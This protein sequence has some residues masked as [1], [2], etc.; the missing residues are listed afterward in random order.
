MR[1]PIEFFVT[2]AHANRRWADDFLR[3]LSEQ[4]I[5]SKQYDYTLWR[6]TA[7]LV[8]QLWQQEIQRA[9]AE[10]DLGLLLVSPAFLG[11]DYITREELPRFVG[12][13]GKAVIPV[14]LQSVNFAR[15]DLKGLEAHQLFRLEGRDAPRAYAQCRD[16]IS[17]RRFVELLFLQIERRLD[18]LLG[19]PV[20]MAARRGNGQK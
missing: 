6:D 15:H 11:S 17:R 9:L 18:R 13:G 3:R 12:T 14:M 1:R 7:I 20:A 16:D 4:L 8:G 19:V 2:Y 10:C 5:P